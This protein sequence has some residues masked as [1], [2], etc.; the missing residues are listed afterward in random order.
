MTFELPV[1]KGMFC[2]KIKY[3][4]NQ[5]A[6]IKANGTVDQVIAICKQYGIAHI[7][8][9]CLEGSWAFNQRPIAWDNAGNT[10]KYVDDILKP[11]VT[12]ITQA[13]IDVWGYQ[14][15]YFDFPEQEAEA[16]LQR[17]PAV[18]LKGLYVD[19]EIEAKN[20]A[21]NTAKYCK[22]L[23]NAPFP[24]GLC[25]Y[26]YPSLHPELAWKTLLNICQ[27][28][29]PQVYWEGSHNPSYQLTQAYDEHKRIL[30]SSLPFLPVGSAYKRSSTWE[31]TPQDVFDFLST[32]KHL[33]F[34]SASFW[35]WSNVQKHVPQNFKAI[36]DFDWNE[37]E[38]PEPPSPPTPSTI[39]QRVGI[40]ER[41]AKARGWE[42]TPGE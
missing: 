29:A 18:G 28:N 26:R 38:T 21:R 16:A 32:T 41:E 15:V 34:Q 14:Y 6:A 24:I 33:E 12:S 9:K 5:D 36:G 37:G 30:G 22:P 2:W 7:I 39:E 27:F 35:E 10:I 20:N 11:W 17:I 31:A 1:G 25:S 42:L 23:L 19:A 4:G 40:L 13:G 3:C 8:V